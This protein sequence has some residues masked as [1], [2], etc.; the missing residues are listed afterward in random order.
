[1][2]EKAALADLLRTVLPNVDF[3]SHK[4]MVDSGLLDSLAIVMIVDKIDRTFG[5]AIP[6]KEIKPEN[7]NSLAAIEAMIQRL[8]R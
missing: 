2:E 6:P 3:S 5:I 8:M 1:M 7:F 4:G